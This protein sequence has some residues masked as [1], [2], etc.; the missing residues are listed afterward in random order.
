MSGPP[1]RASS[2]SDFALGAV[3]GKGAL[4][5]VYGALHK[6]TGLPIALKTMG[7]VGRQRAQALEREVA[8]LARLQHPAIL[9]VYDQ[10]VVTDSDGPLPEGT[11][12]MALEY[13]SGG[14]LEARPP[15]SW[16]E[17]RDLLLQALRGLAYA[18]ARDIVHRD[19]KPGNLVLCGP[20]DLRPGLKLA[21]FGLAWARG[22][23][24]QGTARAGTPSYMPPEQ[25][26]GIAADIGP[27][28]DLYALACVAWHWVGGQPPF[29]LGEVDAILESQVNHPVGRLERVFDVPD[30]LEPLL[31]SMLEKDCR[32]RPRSAAWVA[33][34]VAALPEKGSGGNVRRAHLPPPTHPGALTVLA[35]PEDENLPTSSGPLH[36]ASLPVPAGWRATEVAPTAHVLSGAGLGLLHLRDV[37]VVGRDVERGRLWSALRAVGEG[38]RVLAIVGERGMGAS[39]LA[40]WLCE[41]ASEL[42]CASVF[43]GR[44]PG[45]VGLV[46]SAL[47]VGAG[48]TEPSSLRDHPARRAVLEGLTTG[49]DPADV[50][51]WLHAEAAGGPVIVWLDDALARPKVAD[52]IAGALFDRAAPLLFVVTGAPGESVL[53]DFRYLEGFEAIELGE[54]PAK[55]LAQLLTEQ[56]ALDQRLAATLA[57]SSHGN[58][59]VAL[60][61]LRAAVS[62][63][64][65]T[66]G[67]GG[68]TAPAGHA[69]S[70]EGT[71]DA[72]EEAWVN[73]ALLP[74]SPS[75]RLT[76]AL[77]ALLGREV[78][79][80][81]WRALLTTVGVRAR[82]RSLREMGRSGLIVRTATRWR[83]QGAVAHRL[84]LRELDAH[85][86]AE[87]FHLAAAEILATFPRDA[88]RLERRGIHL[89]DAGQVSE[90]RRVLCEALE[91]LR[92]VGDW[93]RIRSIVERLAAPSAEALDLD[94]RFAVHFFGPLATANLEIAHHALPQLEGLLQLLPELDPARRKRAARMAFQA[95][96]LADDVTGARALAHEVDLTSFDGKR[97]LAMLDL[98]EGLLDDAERRYL[99]LWATVQP[100]Q[101]ARVANGLG[102]VAS[103]RED[104]PAAILWFETAAK[105][106]IDRVYVPLINLALM[107][108]AQAS[109]QEGF[110]HAQH[111]ERHARSGSI[112]AQRVG[113]LTMALAALGAGR[114]TA[115]ER[116]RSPAL[117]VTTTWFDDVEMFRL[118]S[119]AVRTLDLPASGRSFLDAVDL[120][121]RDGPSA[122]TRR[123]RR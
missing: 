17:C 1:A 52:L 116:V 87:R 31:R 28:T 94:T 10:G 79:T 89:V 60:N 78:V 76:L 44:E 24:R 71:P 51:R 18:H 20:A 48:A 45:L 14:S 83:I 118:A 26:L 91:E 33:S 59:G 73:T 47:G 32:N 54:L 112:E 23:E 4:G 119:R 92:K 37:A 106:S 99:E 95:R 72:A 38:T 57:A 103:A 55:D 90:G 25:I 120:R 68:F 61:R 22:A 121:L 29:G 86:G 102:R 117:Y 58:P 84:L 80:A 42:G 104:L 93:L 74:L 41:R 30:S 123:G 75:E 85:G 7:M 62:R 81:E 43:H 19:L 13:A 109:F 9:D 39:R 35:V 66:P 88:S 110:H 34:Q 107:H 105:A 98:S 65:L 114:M 11:A 97:M 111:A 108:V 70:D 64:A 101:A 50:L 21:D 122:S 12:W 36:G 77:G 96:T 49:L 40:R 53:D 56:R 3:L 63:G 2:L 6:A 46:R 82:D 5:T 100:D 16:T 27:W 67:P 15:G 113:A 69:W 8:A 115:F